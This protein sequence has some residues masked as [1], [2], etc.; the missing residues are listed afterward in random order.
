MS[1][2]ANCPV[3]ELD[4]FALDFLENP[5]PFHHDLREAGPVVWLEKY[6]IFAMARYQQ[7]RTALT[8][9]EVYCSSRGVGLSDFAKEAPWRP[10]S[11]ILEADPPKHTRARNV[12]VNVLSKTALQRLST[13]FKDTADK[14]V[15]SL[16]ESR[17]IDAIQ[18][19][20]EAFPLSVFPDTIGLRKDGREN[21]LPYGNMAFNAFGPRNELFQQSFANAQPVVQW[22]SDQCQRQALAPDGIGEQI[23]QSADSGAIT[24]E[25]AGLLVRSLLTAGLD[26]TIFGIGAMLYCFASYPEQWEL[27]RSNPTLVRGAFEEAIRFISPVQTFM[28]TTTRAVEVEGVEIPEGQKVVLFLASA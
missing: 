21:L 24:A 2:P 11:I 12:L 10:P 19:L 15:D 16:V 20:A 7:V 18:D 9:W 26:T 14:L 22:I 3:S 13:D 8:D 28:R 5:Y 4:P 23:Y 27:L 1:K 17:E 25:E 6:N